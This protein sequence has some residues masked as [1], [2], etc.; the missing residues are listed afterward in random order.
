LKVGKKY[1]RQILKVF[2][3]IYISVKLRRNEY[4]E[5]GIVGEEP[6][7]KENTGRTSDKYVGK[8]KLQKNHGQ[9]HLSACDDQP[10][11]FLSPF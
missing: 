8:S 3:I 1:L 10:I 11:R 9:R 5:S 2:K 6:A 4:E 7:D